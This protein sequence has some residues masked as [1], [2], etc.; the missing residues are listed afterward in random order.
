M[1][2]TERSVLDRLLPGIAC[3]RSYE[4]GWLRP[5]IIAGLTVGAVLVPQ[6][7]AYAEL[8]GLPA[9]V[10]LYASV[11]PLVL[12]ALFGSSRQLM[13]GPESTTAVMLATTVAPLA[14]G[15]PSLY[16]ALAGAAALV[17]AGVCALGA[18]ARLG[19][20]ADLLSRPVLLG[21]LAAV[22]LIMVASQLGRLTGVPIG[23]DEFVTQIADFFGG[24]DAI[25]WPTT[26]LGLSVLSVLLVVRWRSPRAPGALIAVVA[27]TAVVALFDLESEGIAV[28][29]SIPA[30][31]PSLGLP[32]AG[33]GQIAEVIP[34]AA[35]I[36][37]VAYTDN[38]LTSR[39]FASR[40]GYEVDANQE[41]AGLA[42]A[43]LAAGFSGGLAIGSS[44][45]RTAIGDAVGS[46]T[47]LTG[48]VAAG[49]V[50]VVV[51]W[52]RPVLEVFPQA[53][54]AAVVIDAAFRLVDLGEIRRLVLV[55]RSELVLSLV[56][57][58]GVLV[59]G[60][61]AGVLIAVG[62]SVAVIVAR[63]ARPHDAV[64][65]RTPD[66]DGWHSI[67]RFEDAET[68]PG[69]VVYRFDAPLFFANA[70]YFKR[71]VLGVL[72]RSPDDIEWFLLDAEAI[73][74]VDST[75]LRTMVEL[76][77]ELDEREIV[78]VLARA[79]DRL[80]DMMDRAGFTGEIGADHFFP[81]T[82]AAVQAF[83]ERGPGG[84]IS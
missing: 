28:V 71:Q 76:V 34:A 78:F 33:I 10:G 38:M 37:I 41:L 4:P 50:V 74:L 58:A 84:R 73:S 56:T 11:L 22:A 54:L 80:R 62:L 59:V 75:A 46:R 49:V 15:D 81:T 61:L 3:A 2:V 23:S 25:D 16:L 42:A 6:S 18:I 40:N 5:D 8:A 20:I 26:A 32:A 55:G 31:L 47:Q 43:N 70:S 48:V 83:M 65:G 14:A 53:A 60:I 30:G 13:V 51:L 72:D 82:R 66:I 7:M 19:F 36:A 77:D 57:L 79:R 24:L 52:L 12:Y 45:S 1:A 9:V 21:Y 17:V 39:A 69:L 63:T 35:A 29:G 67:E 27:A 68:I 44:A 64:L